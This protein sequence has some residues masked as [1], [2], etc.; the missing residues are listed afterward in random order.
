MDWQRR[1]GYV[2]FAGA[3]VSGINILGSLLTQNHTAVQ[4]I[5]PI[6]GL[7]FVLRVIVDIVSE[8]EILQPSTNL[9]TRE[10]VAASAIGGLIG[11]GALYASVVTT[12][13]PSVVSSNLLSIA[14]VVEWL[15]A[16]SVVLFRLRT[17]NSA[18]SETYS[19]AH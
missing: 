8:Y 18:N 3:I 2:I 10:L 11:G 5:A 19:D 13:V 15:L 6:V 1:I 9:S 4:V 17:A 7:P 14:V 16:Y 12:A